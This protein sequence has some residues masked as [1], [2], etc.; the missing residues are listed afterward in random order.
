MPSLIIEPIRIVLLDNQALVRAGIRLLIENQ[1]GMVV[2]GEAGDL[3]EGLKIITELKPDIILL[4]LNL[5]KQPDF[6]IIPSIIDASK[7]A[8]LI[9]ITD[10]DDSQILQQAV[11]DGVVGIVSTTQKPETLIKAI[12]KVFAGEVWLERT[13]VADMLSSLS[14]NQHVNKISPEM[15]GIT[16]L[17]VREKEVIRLI[18]QGY[19]NKTISAQLNIRE[20]TVRHHLT[21][22]YGKLGVSDRLELLV[23]AHRYG[24][25]KRPTQ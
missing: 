19:K 25:V 7:Q 23:Y 8:R 10:E 14:H 3:S 15:E 12:G 11:K 18:G 9:L 1:N 13:M 6:D 2:A 5:D 24:L 21:S 16:H 20:T 4:K 22:I 17:S